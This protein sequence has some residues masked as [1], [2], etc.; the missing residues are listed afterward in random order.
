MEYHDD[1]IRIWKGVV[2]ACLKILYRHSLGNT[3]ENHEKRK[4]VVKRAEN[5]TVVPL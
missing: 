1:W 5:R 4:I 2:V 3:E